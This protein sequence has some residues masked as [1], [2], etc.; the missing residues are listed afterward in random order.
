MLRRVK[1]SKLCSQVTPRNLSAVTPRKRFLVAPKDAK[2]TAEYIC[3]SR[4]E[5]FRRHAGRHLSRLRRKAFRKREVRG[6]F[7]PRH[8]TQIPRPL[9]HFSLISQPR[10]FFL[11]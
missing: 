6:H 11:T 7:R 5:P 10:R 4:P 1:M 9:T 3:L 8:Q 2:E